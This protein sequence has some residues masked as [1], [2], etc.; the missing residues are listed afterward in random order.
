MKTLGVNRV[1]WLVQAGGVASLLLLFGASGCVASNR[2]VG[3]K[4]QQDG[5]WYGEFGITGHLNEITVLS[6]SRLQKLSVIGD[7]NFVV[8]QDGV[9]LGKIE[10]WGENNF[11]S[12]PTDLIVRK[13]ISGSKSLVVPRAPGEPPPRRPSEPMLEPR[14]DGTPPEAEPLAEETVEPPQ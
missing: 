14:D 4:I 2:I 3:H 7:G 8:V 5:A 6:G 10:I 12:V 1:R 11:V 13:N 9:T